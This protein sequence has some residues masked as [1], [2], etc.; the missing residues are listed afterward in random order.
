MPRLPD[1]VEVLRLREFRLL[2]LGQ[3]V[4]LLGDGMVRVALAFAVLHIGGS[5]ADVGLVL[6]AQTVTLVACL[7][8][9]GV[10]ADRT[11]ARGVMVTA[12]L[13]RLASQGTMAVLLIDGSAEVWSLAL[14]A[15]LTGAATGFFNPASTGLLPAVVDA[16]HLQQANGLRATAMAAGEIAGP[17]IA[18]VLVAT[19][20]PGWALGLDAV[21]FAVSA[22]FLA[23][24]RL[25]ARAAA[26]RASFVA[27]LREGWRAF[28]ERRWVWTFVASAAIG[29][30]CWG[31]W[32]ALGPVVADEELGGAAAWGAILAAM[33]AGGLLGGV[34]AIRARPERP[35]VVATLAVLLF[36][37]PMA[38]LAAGVSAALIAAGGIVGGAGMM[39][40]NS[41]WESTLQ[42]HIP[43]EQLARVSAYDWFG[44]MAFKPVGLAIWG[45]VAVAIGTQEALWLAFAILVGS[46]LC[47]LAVPEIRALRR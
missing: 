31:A 4:S 40:G 10:V 9:G 18:G 8:A 6:A 3:T 37:T 21:T 26:A 45:P 5:A 28:R 12:D 20:G 39:I 27:D 33:G 30:A 22:A 36:A 34:V 19:A 17:V 41:V 32:S 24:L 11:Q 38:M 7:L 15:G 46:A 42:R 43:I 44:S 29:N 1:S 14:L 47:V 23:Q 16:E 25:P 35:A 2:F 13:A